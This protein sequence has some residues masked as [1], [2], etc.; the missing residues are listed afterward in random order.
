MKRWCLLVLTISLLV[1][2]SSWPA[3]A[4]AAAELVEDQPIPLSLEQ[5]IAAAL[6]GNLN[7]RLRVIDLQQAEK[8]LDRALFIGDDEM[9]EA[10]QTKLEQ[11]RETYNTSRRDLISSVRSKY[12][13][14]LQQEAAVQNQAKALEQARTQL[15]IDQAKFEAGMISALDLQRTKNSLMNTEFS[16]QSALTTLETKYMEMNQMLGLEL[17]SPIVLTE[18]ISVEFV[19]FDLELEQAYQLALAHNKGVAQAREK[20]DKALEK[21]RAYDNPYTP[22]VDLENAK[23]E[24]EKAQIELKREESDLYFSIRRDYYELKK[25]ANDVLAKERDLE[26]E[27]QN[28]MAAEAKYA[29]GAI[30][31]KQVVDQQEALAK[32]EQA[33]TQA[34]WDYSQYRTQFLITIGLEQGFPGGGSDGQ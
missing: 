31:N 21:V 34:L 4:G 16:Y 27:Q 18:K 12:Y 33:Y 8:E 20:L 25:R 15:E 22:R 2:A 28:L 23:V 6:A 30:S 26:H 29:A 7:L 17:S 9:I 32:A 1:A 3:A 24:V 5:A 13:E 11:A 19:P 14:V 10:A